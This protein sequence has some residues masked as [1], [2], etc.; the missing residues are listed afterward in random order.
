MIHLYINIILLHFR[1]KIVQYEKAYKVN[2]QQNVNSHI[3][4]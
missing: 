1:L 3:H 4:I 2:C